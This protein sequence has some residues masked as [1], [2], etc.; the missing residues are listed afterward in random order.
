MSGKIQ[1]SVLRLAYLVAIAGALLAVP[2][3]A[4]GVKDADGRM[5]T[6]P[7]NGG[8]HRITF[9]A[10]IVLRLLATAVIGGATGAVVAGA[11]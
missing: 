3:L 9:A 6:M 1:K 10:A 4:E 2:E 5:T 7:E 8:L 11:S